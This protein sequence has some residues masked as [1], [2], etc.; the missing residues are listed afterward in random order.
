MKKIILATGGFD[1]VHEGHIEY[2]KS[3]AELGDLLIVG[4]NSDDW[5][6]RKKGYAFQNAL[7]RM[8]VL[9]S[10]RMVD[11]VLLMD[12]TDGTAIRFIEEC[13]ERYGR[14]NEYWFVNG[15]DRTA[16]NIPEN[17]PE[18]KGNLHFKYGV[19]GSKKMNSSSDLVKNVSNIQSSK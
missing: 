9:S 13:M 11:D 17:V 19:G 16:K 10:L 5:L 4:L 15:G 6:E 7:T 12:D 2:L 1:P 8:V 14:D 18:F 3:A